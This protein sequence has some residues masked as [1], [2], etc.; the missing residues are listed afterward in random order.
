MVHAARRLRRYFR[1]H[2]IRVF[3]DKP[4]EWILSKPNGSQRLAKWAIELGEHDIEYKDDNSVKGQT[5]IKG[6]SKLG[7]TSTPLNEEARRIERERKLP[8]FDSEEGVY[9]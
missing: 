4:I 6:P 3:T 7:L 1:D 5:P 2:P 9:T 8:S